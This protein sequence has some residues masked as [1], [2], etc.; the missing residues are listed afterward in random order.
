MAKYNA[1]IFDLDSTITNANR[2]PLRACE[3]LVEHH[4]GLASHGIDR[5]VEHLYSHYYDGIQEVV[6]GAPFVPPFRIVYRA[7][8]QSLVDLEVE[9]DD[10]ILRRGVEL[11]MHY[12]LVLAEIAQGAS[13]ILNRLTERG[14]K[15]GVFSNSFI[16]HTETILNRLGLSHYFSVIADCG[17][18][19]AYKPMREA[20]EFMLSRLEEEPSLTLSVGDE[21]YADVVGAHNM[22][23]DA[24]WVNY[25][26]R[27]LD[28][29]LEKFGE[30]TRPILTISSLHEL[31]E[32]L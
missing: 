12:H 15:I 29:H 8:K 11:M 19:K 25:R 32:F 13:E 14:I 10:P 1:V 24:V 3:W 21:Y 23:M 6:A 4:P 31:L 22:G 17:G 26:G 27:S 2:F 7:L 16:G 18:P 28:A 20:F 9:P 5:L 30:S